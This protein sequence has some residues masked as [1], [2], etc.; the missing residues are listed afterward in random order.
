MSIPVY[1][2]SIPGIVFCLLI[3]GLIQH[4]ECRFLKFHSVIWAQ[5]GVDSELFH[6]RKL[7]IPLCIDLGL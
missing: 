4:S 6:G 5:T 3:L 7:N 1:L 2:P